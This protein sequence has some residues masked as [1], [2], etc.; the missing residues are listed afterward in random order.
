MAE[1]SPKDTVDELK[2]MVIDYAKQ[3][4]VDPLKR[5]GKWAGFGVG[6]AICLAIG[7]FLIG[8]GIL[9]MFQSMSWTDGNWSFAPYL[10][11]FAILVAF[12]GACFVAMGRRP[13]WLEEE[14]R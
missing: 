7:A 8:L 13:D 1:K 11:V 10:I 6:G 3:E 4:T 2:A 5:L 12:A 9:R 14:T